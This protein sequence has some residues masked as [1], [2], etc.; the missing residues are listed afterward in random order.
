MDGK[1]PVL[2]AC[3]AKTD[4]ATFAVEVGSSVMKSRAVKVLAKAA[5]AYA[6]VMNWQELAVQSHVRDHKTEAPSFG[7]EI[8]GSSVAA[9]PAR[10]VLGSAEG[11]RAFS[12]V[13]VWPNPSVKRTRNGV[14][15]GP[16]GR[17]VYPRP[18]GP[19]ATP[20]RAAYLER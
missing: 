16:R 3:G 7:S 1:S 20:L 17:V 4:T 15:P 10:Q 2:S 13:K 19:G 5:T 14:A 8:Q 18:H 9:S 11:C 12:G 6:G